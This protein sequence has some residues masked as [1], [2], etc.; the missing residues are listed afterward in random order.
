MVVACTRLLRGSGYVA[1]DGEVPADPQHAA[2][3]SEYA[4]V[5]APLRRLG[6]RYAGEVCLALCAGEDVP[7]WVTE[8]LHDLPATLQQ[9]G[10]RSRRYERAVLDLV[11]AAL[12][13]GRVGEQFAGVV[14]DVDDEDHARGTVTV[15]DP[16]I[17]APVRGRRRGAPA[18]RG[19]R[20]DADRRRPPAPPG[21]VL[22]R[23]SPTGPGTGLVHQSPDS[24]RDLALRCG[25]T[26]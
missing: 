12:L 19:G 2:L 4:H 20:G 21:R 15:A 18:R 11:E 22:G 25:G 24:G 8:R 5:T 17:E 10:Q 1:F 16:A 6:D 23:L 26:P 9:S 13:R 7:G 14:V 3:A